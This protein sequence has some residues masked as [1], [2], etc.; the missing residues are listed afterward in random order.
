MH[1]NTEV[2]NICSKIELSKMNKLIGDDYSTVDWNCRLK[3]AISW[4]NLAEKVI[5][6]LNY[7]ELMKIYWIKLS[8][9]IRV[10]SAHPL[11]FGERSASYANFRVRRTFQWTIFKLKPL[12][13]SLGF[14]FIELSVDLISY[15]KPK[16]ISIVFNVFMN[17]N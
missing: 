12:N 5:F 3:P 13:E 11:L 9:L 8:M 16:T 15:V 6:T 2:V 14:S 1:S 7:M 4:S 17:S 10:F